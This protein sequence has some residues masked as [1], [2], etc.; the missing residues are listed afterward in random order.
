M[1]AADF[2]QP[3]GE[4]TTDLF[5]GVDL[6]AAV[7]AWIADAAARADNPNAQRSWVLHRAYAT[8][9]D[10]MHAGLASESKAGASAA[11]SAEQ[12]RY[13][14]RKAREHLAAYQAIASAPS[15]VTEVRPVW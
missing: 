13:W 15:T 7:T 8:I 11:R 2:I 12:F 9:A 3:T 5:P 10:R 14:S 6:E 4:L 1:T